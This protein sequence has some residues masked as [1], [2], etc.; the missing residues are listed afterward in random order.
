MRSKHSHELV[1]KE[2]TKRLVILEAHRR[3]VTDIVRRQLIAEEVDRY[4]LSTIGMTFSQSLAVQNRCR[5]LNERIDE[6]L[7]SN[8]PLLAARARFD[9]VV[10]RESEEGGARW[11]NTV[12][13][14]ASIPIGLIAPPLGGAIDIVNG[15]D[16]I[17]NRD[18]TL[19]G[20][21]NILFAIPM[22]GDALQVGHGPYKLLMDIS[23]AATTPITWPIKKLAGMK[24]VKDLG[25]VLLKQ[26]EKI[27]PM[28]D[29]VSGP[30]ASAISSAIERVAPETIRK[31]V[32]KFP[33]GTT[34]VQAILLTIKESLVKHMTEL[35][36]FIGK[37]TP[38][39]VLKGRPVQ[40]GGEKV[41]RYTLRGGIKQ[42][43]ERAAAQL[44]DDVLR[45]N[46]SLLT[47]S[48]ELVDDVVVSAT[49]RVENGAVIENTT[50]L[51]N[52]ITSGRGGFINTGG[53]G[54]TPSEA[55]V[56]A[57]GI[58]ADTASSRT[59]AQP[60]EY[61]IYQISDDSSAVGLVSVIGGKE[62]G[63]HP[64]VPMNI[65]GTSSTQT[66]SIARET[67]EKV[68]ELANVNAQIASEVGEEAA[69]Q[70]GQRAR[71]ILPRKGVTSQTGS[72]TQAVA[73]PS[74]ASAD[75]GGIA[76]PSR[77]VA[78]HSD[79]DYMAAESR[80]RRCKM[81]VRKDRFLL[82]RYSYLSGDISLSDLLD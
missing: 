10:L 33:T 57:A 13:A 41:L 55:I 29:D 65:V 47:K 56:R 62:I 18:E 21:L 66:G 42:A 26:A 7:E 81:N 2:I 80:V 5:V 72:G 53:Y 60:I 70:T 67:A 11:F 58:G 78:V 4:Y 17:A 44:T 49:G 20:A 73:D 79:E 52:F 9:S 22:I 63:R 39:A 82:E 61:F 27:M 76:G 69:H 74:I 28:L 43:L 51:G 45:L 8:F 48:A 71:D 31:L 25:G 37:K 6:S 30:A 54:S 64:A 14:I 23:R 75:I 36:E 38:E 1:V 12:A 68:S 34:P 35:A 16:L 77:A 32:A 3:P 15:I 24:W 50:E 46:S 19:W 40:V 59:V